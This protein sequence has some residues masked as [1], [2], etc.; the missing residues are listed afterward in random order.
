ML[1]ASMGRE[2]PP[3]EREPE[4]GPEHR[5][6]PEDAA[7]PGR[8]HGGAPVR[9]DVWSDIACPWCFIGK[10][11]LARALAAGPA[12]SVDVFWHAFELRPDM[13]PE[14]LD[15][16]RFY[17]A[18]FGGERRRDAIFERTRAAGAEEG[19]AL[20]FGRIK[21]P[22]TRLGHRII[23][24]TPR[25][26]AQDRVVEALFR[27]HFERGVDVGKEDEVIAFLES[28][29]A[30]AGADELRRRLAAGAGLDEVLDDEAA[31]AALGIGGVPFFV[32]NRRLA[33]SGAQ[34]PEVFEGLIAEARGASDDTA[35]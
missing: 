18:K 31:A 29:R 8:P 7:S 6:E 2:P 17:A 19:L 35:R 21:A 25:G 27:A 22:N 32:A 30:I 3:P 33:V 12:G 26:A 34:P 4:P 5:P 13:P 28:E 23:Q 14:G 11:R 1:A 20:D 16:P 15:G 10:R 24:L 9:I